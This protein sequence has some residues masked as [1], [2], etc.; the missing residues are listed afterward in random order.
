MGTVSHSMRRHTFC[1]ERTLSLDDNALSISGDGETHLISYQDIQSIKVA[2]HGFGSSRS[3]FLFATKHHGKH[4]VTSHHY[5]SLGL[6]ED[7]SSTFYPFLSAL[8]ERV[9][10]ANPSARFK[11]GSVL[12]IVI[13]LTVFLLTA[14]VTGVLLYQVIFF[15]SEGTDISILFGILGSATAAYLSAKT[16]VT[17]RVRSFDPMNV[18]FEAM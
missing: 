6:F 15:G 17:N 2:Y 1:G 11:E 18:P 4:K 10:R 16:I 5:V 7:R 3:E 13:A 9:A 8:C 14:G 12:Y